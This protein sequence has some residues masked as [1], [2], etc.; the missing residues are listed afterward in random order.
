M[1]SVQ[2]WPACFASRLLAK[3]GPIG[4]ILGNML[5]VAGSSAL[6]ELH[7]THCAVS[8][9]LMAL[10]VN[11]KRAF[12]AGKLPIQVHPNSAARMGGMVGDSRNAFSCKGTPVRNKVT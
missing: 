2:K 8:T 5:N 4:T 12:I 10:N 11:L 7:S 3:R 6:V 9:A 1:S